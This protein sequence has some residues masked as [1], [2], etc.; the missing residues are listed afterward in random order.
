MTRLRR[1]IGGC[2]AA[3]A[4][5]AAG[6]SAASAATFYVSTS[7][8]DKASC[9]T[10]AEACRTIKVAVERSETSAGPARIE[11]GPGIYTELLSMK[12]ADDDGITING[13]GSGS[14]GTEIVGPA[15]TEA[16]MAV[17]ALALFGAPA[18]LSNLQ[19]VTPSEDAGDAIEG[20]AEL[21]LENVVVGMRDAKSTGVGVAV[22]ELGS[23]AMTGSAVYMEA[24]TLGTAVEAAGV[25]ASIASSTIVTVP[26]AEAEGIATRYGPLTVTDSTLR[27]EG[28]NESAGIASVDGALTLSNDTVTDS[29]TFE[30]QG[31]VATLS[32]PATI[33]DVT[34]TM[35]GAGNENPG[36]AVEA[37]TAR[38]EGVNVGGSWNGP[39]LSADFGSVTVD[40]S[41][42]LAAAS[43]P[44]PAAE[45]V[46]F[47][48]G[49]GLLIQRSV[50]QAGATAPHGALYVLDGDLAVDS[51]EVLGGKS[52]IELENEAAKERS[53]TVTASTLDAG[54]LGVAGEAGDSGLEIIAGVPGSIVTG[55]L[56]GSI[57]FEPAL[58]KVE[59]GARSAS[60]SC[61][62]SQVPSQ[63]QNAGGA[64]GS[65]ECPGGADGNAG[66]EAATLGALFSE[67][68]GGYA[69]N[70]SSAAIDSVPS[71]AITLPF[72][73][74][75]SS[76]DLAGNPR[77]VQIGSDGV[78]A[79]YQD[80]GALQLPAQA[81]ACTP[82]SVSTPAPTSPAPAVKPPAGVLSALTISPSS[83]FAAAS[84]ATISSA[85]HKAGATVSYRDSQAALTT[86][87]V[88]VPLSGRA[89]GH[90]CNK[91]SHSN[92]HSRRCTYYRALSSFTHTDTAGANS[93]Q[94]SG[95][96]K[97][98]KLTPGSYKLQAV[99]HDAAGDGAAVSKDFTIK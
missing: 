36:I 79:A 59:S 86:F 70:P 35:S 9:E 91:P 95:R 21:Q 51:S 62:Y 1:L 22:L 37:G 8:N 31:I 25:P 93:F 76:T 10:A 67:L 24:G 44:A 73:Q 82:A 13:A 54:T 23:L 88:L 42:L 98:R 94:F 29:S 34:V 49:A 41:H 63:Q 26:G 71:S 39:P 61:S 11:V 66:I 68:P 40:D 97:G 17:I 53:V 90:S 78:C 30:S 33:T 27:L 46:S 7:G 45:F 50:L 99:A 83:F 43:G 55:A 92:R 18:A 2:A 84:G 56:E 57:S 52:A 48:E 75:P 5:A 64:S 89:Q 65:I 14:G 38:L 28:S 96:I 6:A 80:P 58:A 4:I 12:S 3:A 19:V 69:L 74:T 87:T 15:K 81:S 60:I 85:G 47:D 20:N 16:N 32:S 72:G 77:S